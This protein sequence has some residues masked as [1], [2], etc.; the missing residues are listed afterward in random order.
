MPEPKIAKLQ[1]VARDPAFDA[2]STD[3]KLLPVQVFTGNLQY[4]VVANPWLR[5]ELG[6]LYRL[7]ATADPTRVMVKPRGETAHVKA[8]WEDFWEATE[9]VRLSTEAQEDWEA[10]FSTGLGALLEPRELLALPG[11]GGGHPL[12]RWRFRHP[13]DRRG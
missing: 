10:D 2:G 1:V 6:T 11:D 12:H 7:L 5:P 4:S 3:L 8:V 13:S 9:I